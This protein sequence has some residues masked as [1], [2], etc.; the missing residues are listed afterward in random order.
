MGPGG[1][2]SWNPRKWKGLATLGLGCTPRIPNHRD[3]NRRL[4]ISWR[5]VSKKNSLTKGEPEKRKSY[6]NWKKRLLKFFPSWATLL[7]ERQPLKALVPIHVT[8]FGMVTL[9]L[10]I[11]ELWWRAF[12]SKLI[13]IG[14]V[15]NKMVSGK[16][17]VIRITRVP[18]MCYRKIQLAKSK[19]IIVQAIIEVN[20]IYISFAPP[21]S[22][23]QIPQIS[24]NFGK[25]PHSWGSHHLSS[26]IIPGNIIPYSRKISLAAYSQVLWRADYPPNKNLLRAM[27]PKRNMKQR[28]HSRSFALCLGYS[29]PTRNPLKIQKMKSWSKWQAWYYTRPGVP[30]SR[31]SNE[32][33]KYDDYRWF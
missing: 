14:H 3:P 30:Q 9:A 11:M 7:K 32:S 19:Q 23:L 33:V 16:G 21:I 6:Q 26:P 13:L 5:I 31:Q 29:P 15:L 27:V 10:S 25:I 20:S 12:R 17:W 8:E 22:N 24:G 4:T 2:D 18:L 1:L 28:L